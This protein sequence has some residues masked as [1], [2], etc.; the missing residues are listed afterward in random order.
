MKNERA[1]PCVPVPSG[2]DRAKKAAVRNNFTGSRVVLAGDATQGE[3]IMSRIKL[4]L[5]AG[6]LATGLSAG[7]QAMPVSNLATVDTGV[8]PEQTRYVCNAWGRC[9]WR[10]NRFYGGPYAYY[11]GP[12]FY[13]PRFYAGPRWYGP[14]YRAYRW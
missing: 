1:R 9:W 2:L 6:V 8:Q 3:T 13:G 14:R 5:I 10:P 7:A 11:G 12:R 4:A